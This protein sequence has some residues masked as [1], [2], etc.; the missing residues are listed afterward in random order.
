[1]ATLSFLLSYL[2]SSSH[3][4]L[5]PPFIQLPL[6]PP[7]LVSQDLHLSSVLYHQCV[8]LSGQQ[9]VLKAQ[10]NSVLEF[11][12]EFILCILEHQRPL[13]LLFYLTP[14]CRQKARCPILHCIITPII[15]F[16]LGWWVRGLGVTCHE[17]QDHQDTLRQGHL[18]LY[19]QSVAA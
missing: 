1:M 14:P 3:S 7:I 13:Y 4:S 2:S 9:L 12:L 10:C 18:S 5:H 11:T 6:S 17:K 19:G 8:C 16:R 15:C